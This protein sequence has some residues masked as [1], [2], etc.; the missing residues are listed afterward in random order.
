[1]EYLDGEVDSNSAWETIKGYYEFEE[2][3]AMD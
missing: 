3:Q 2:A 1:L